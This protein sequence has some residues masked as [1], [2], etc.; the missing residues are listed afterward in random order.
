MPAPLKEAKTSPAPSMATA[1]ASTPLTWTHMPEKRGAA[2]DAVAGEVGDQVAV[3]VGGEQRRR[4][5]RQQLGGAVQAEQADAGAGEGGE[6]VAA[7][8]RGD[9]H[10]VHAVHHLKGPSE[11]V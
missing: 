10:G 7:G 8:V 6:Q 9:G 4:H 1:S 3:G 5:R 11:G 2:V